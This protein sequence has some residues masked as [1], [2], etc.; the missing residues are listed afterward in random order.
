MKNSPKKLGRIKVGAVD[1]I[2][3]VLLASLSVFVCCGYPT[4]IYIPEFSLCYTAV[5]CTVAVLLMAVSY[6]LIGRLYPILLGFAG[7]IACS[8]LFEGV[9]SAFLNI[10]QVLEKKFVIITSEIFQYA[11]DFTTGFSNVDYDSFVIITAVSAL[12]LA[13][14]FVRCYFKGKW[15]GIA[16]SLTV[17]LAFASFVG[18][19][20][21]NMAFLLCSV[22]VCLVLLCSSG[23]SGK[24]FGHQK[25]LF[26]AALVLSML[27]GAIGCTADNVKNVSDSIAAAVGLPGLKNSASGDEI[28]LPDELFAISSQYRQNSYY[29]IAMN[30]RKFNNAVLMSSYTSFGGMVYLYSGSYYA[31]N[32]STW[33]DRDDNTLCAP[34]NNITVK[35]GNATLVKKTSS[36]VLPDYMWSGK[37]SDGSNS[38]SISYSTLVRATYPFN[39]DRYLDILD[40]KYDLSNLDGKDYPNGESVSAYILERT[41]L[42][43]VRRMNQAY[44]SDVDLDA[45]VRQILG[46]DY[47]RDISIKQAVYALRKY[48]AS[49]TYTINPTK[50]ENYA[51][52]DREKSALYNF[53]FNTK[54]GYCVHYAT[55]AALL[56]REMGFVTRY[57]VGYA[58]QAKPNVY[59]SVYDKN[60]HAWVEVFVE[61]LGWMP[62]ELTFGESGMPSDV[63]E[64]SSDAETSV[65]ADTSTEESSNADNSIETPEY[66]RDISESLIIS[67]PVDKSID[68]SNDESDVESGEKS[69]AG[70]YVCAVAVLLLIAVIAFVI[71]RTKGKSTEKRIRFTALPDDENRLL[72]VLREEWRFM[73]GLLELI[74]ISQSTGEDTDSLASRIEE[75]I[76]EALI[77]SEVIGL[78][79]AAEFGGKANGEGAKLCGAYVLRLNS[80]VTGRLGLFKRW[81][82][83]L[84]G[85][86]LMK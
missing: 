36:I 21:A 78:F 69:F 15:Y 52:Y 76:P 23:L 5:I 30:D 64:E 49:M 38:T 18:Y 84:S 55:A 74:G 3:G 33:S 42:Y 85:K 29:K 62:L 63:T 65:N 60:A 82:A 47:G 35:Y 27:A 11:P 17:V 26:A 48:F 51:K 41:D 40:R 66:S 14:I 24:A 19:E 50:S 44:S 59:T 54:E 81:R 61:N 71:R 58:F 57:S 75:E 25:K 28:P 77:T 67:N 20:R 70:A 4:Y 31:Y 43:D 13:V 7:V 37:R 56:L 45:L 9:R 12:L 53:V 6:V 1:F 10:P 2:L 34:W 86:L 8:L 32:G 73:L 80:I 72:S 46:S 39:S 22:V 83:Y 16:F 79:L 68:V